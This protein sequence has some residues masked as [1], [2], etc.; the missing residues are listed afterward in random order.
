MWWGTL[1]AKLASLAADLSAVWREKS[2]EATG[3]AIQ[4]GKNDAKTLDTLGAI[5]SPSSVADTD[6]LWRRNKAKFGPSGGL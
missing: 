5:N 6:E 1:A 4:Q 2:A 3:A